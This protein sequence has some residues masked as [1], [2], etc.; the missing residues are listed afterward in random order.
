MWEVVIGKGEGVLE[1]RTFSQFYISSQHE[2]VC[3]VT[4][5]SLS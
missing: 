2:A 4:K 5:Y 3:L 1:A